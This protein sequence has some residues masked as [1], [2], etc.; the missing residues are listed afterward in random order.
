MGLKGRSGTGGKDDIKGVRGVKYRIRKGSK[1]RS[2]S[3]FQSRRVE[4]HD[5]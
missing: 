4:L 5:S 1:A 3:W 2:L